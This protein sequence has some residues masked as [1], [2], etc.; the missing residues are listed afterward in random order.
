MFGGSAKTNADL[1]RK[2][3]FSEQAMRLCSLVDKP[4]FS[5]TFARRFSEHPNHK[6]ITTSSL[7]GLRAKLRCSCKRVTA[8]RSILKYPMKFSFNHSRVTAGALGF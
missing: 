8:P 4:H 6:I 5:P 3:M 2:G 1:F 7:E